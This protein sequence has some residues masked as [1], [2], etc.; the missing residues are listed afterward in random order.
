[1]QINANY[2]TIPVPSAW[3][4]LHKVQKPGQESIALRVKGALSFVESY[5]G[6][7]GNCEDKQYSVS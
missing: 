6:A 2:K 3:L 7:K 4:H 5:W 1:M